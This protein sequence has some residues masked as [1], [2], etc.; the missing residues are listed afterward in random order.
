[1][2]GTA[3]APGIG[4]IAGTLVGGTLGSVVGKLSSLGEADKAGI[5][6]DLDA[7]KVQ[8]LIGQEVMMSM[9]F[10]LGVPVA[11]KAV[12]AL[13]KSAGRL[14]MKVSG[15]SAR[16][17]V[18][19]VLERTTGK[20]AEDILTAMENADEFKGA[21]DDVRK[22]ENTRVGQV[23]QETIPVK[24]KEQVYRAL[25]DGKI[26]K[27]SAE[28]ALEVLQKEPGKKL[29]LNVN[30]GEDPL[31]V[32]MRSRVTQDLATAQKRIGEKFGQ[33]MQ[34]PKVR[35]ATRGAKVDVGGQL[36][37]FRG[38]LK[39]N[40]L[41]DDAD[42]WVTK[43]GGGDVLG[44]D[45]AALRDAWLEIQKNVPRRSGAQKLLKKIGPEGQIPVIGK[46]ST[47][48][49]ELSFDGA[50]KLRQQ[51]D[52]IIDSKRGF[53][54]GVHQMSDG[55]LKALKSLSYNVGNNAINAVPNAAARSALRAR[56][57]IYSNMRT[58]LD[59]VGNQIFKGKEVMSSRFKRV[60]GH[61]QDAVEFQKAYRSLMTGATNAQK[62]EN[63]VGFLTRNNSYR[64]LTDLFSPSLA[65]Q[66]TGIVRQTIGVVTAGTATSP[67]IAP[68]IAASQLRRLQTAGKTA[69]F[70]GK[71]SSE[72]RNILLR[73]PEMLEGL[74]KSYDQAV[75]M[76]DQIELQTQQQME[77]VQQAVQGQGQPQQQQEQG[78]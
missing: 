10:G 66:N 52:S 4:T 74:V 40:G 76:G 61:T 29:S 9:A 63:S 54:K 38:Y 71:M 48:A 14:A 8:T 32:K 44:S 31:I 53:D 5:R 30:A 23:G 47:M 35:A 42:K 1:M 2:I 24:S 60:F 13:A 73:N 41:I 12:G 75:S 20:P 57:T 46:E 45:R 18:A 27:E 65:Q 15:K 78:R 28:E 34:D 7:Q 37:E 51:L 50:I 68:R 6:T 36:D 21:L 26:T 58:D 3:I 55:A 56:N 16:K 67:S 19:A 25:Q 39:Q 22:W 72:Q 77:A 17:N 62:A 49:R 59:T 11:A 64:S 43:S 69:E 33:V 70:I